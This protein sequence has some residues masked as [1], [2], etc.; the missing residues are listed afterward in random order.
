MVQGIR[1]GGAGTPRLQVIETRSGTSPRV[2]TIETTWA[3]S[4]Q[5]RPAVTQ[6]TTGSSLVSIRSNE[7]ARS[8]HSIDAEHSPFDRAEATKRIGEVAKLLEI[9]ARSGASSTK[10]SALERK[11]ISWAGMY[12]LAA[13]GLFGA[14][15]AR[16]VRYAEFDRRMSAF[17]LGGE[18]EQMLDGLPRPLL[19]KLREKGAS[20]IEVFTAR[21][22]AVTSWTKSKAPMSLREMEK[23]LGKEALRSLLSSV[24]REQRAMLEAG[25]MA[26][27]EVHAL[28]E[29][30]KREDVD[31]LIIGAG[32]GGIGA[33]NEL[34]DR[35]QSVTVLEAKA[36]SGGRAH[37]EKNELG[38]PL[39][40]GGAWVHQSNENPLMPIISALG[41]RTFST[42]K[43]QKVFAG[44][45]PKKD[46]QVLHERMEHVLEK[47]SALAEKRPEARP[48]NAQIVDH[49]LDKLAAEVLGPL[50][51][52]LELNQATIKEIAG[53]VEEKDDRLV[54]GGLGNIIHAFSHGLPILT[55]TPAEKIRWGKGHVEIE[56]GGRTF[57]AKQLIFAASPK[58]FAKLE[59]DPP[60]PEWKR[61][62]I[63]SFQMAH[64]EKIALKFAPG[65]LKDVDPFERAVAIDP[66]GRAVELLMKPFGEDVG[67]VLVG[68]DWAKEMT[69]KPEQ[70]ALEYALGIMAGEYGSEL[71][72]NFEKGTRTQWSI[73]P[74]VEGTW[75]VAK[76]GTEPNARKNYC[77]VVD[78]TLYVAGEACGGQWSASVN[79][80]FFSGKD[81]ATRIVEG[82]DEKKA[83]V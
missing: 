42:E 21:S 5:F 57:R 72:D 56:S 8:K 1:S 75:A 53:A 11:E 58:V 35:G 50:E 70:E 77:D 54:E 43:F 14:D 26:G 9:A 65:T 69:Q 38:M 2:T 76:P 52:A 60:L 49:P 28:V 71:K 74:H 7:S 59:F 18:L 63:E 24:T 22:Q 48:A 34:I 6:T 31:V 47:W 16:P 73:D 44:G 27:T 37:T 78:D 20:P 40:H 3:P 46:A 61:K 67:V 19:K 17:G 41:Y 10:K 30:K 13:Q 80:A 83:A 25:K 51:I 32:A 79:G 62:A 4:T 15:A 36:R 23:E 45:D 68:A 66:E 33:A 81:T 39:D 64:F 55:S 82:D 12:R 29:S